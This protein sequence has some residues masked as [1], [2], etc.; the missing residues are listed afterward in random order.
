MYLPLQ[1]CLI[2]DTEYNY[3]MRKTLCIIIYI[4]C[5]LI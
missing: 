5:T 4:K 2:Y 3:M 1:V